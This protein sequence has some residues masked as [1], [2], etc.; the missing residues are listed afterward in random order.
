MSL[1][2]EDLI[3]RSFMFEHEDGLMHRVQPMPAGCPS[4]HWE[5]AHRVTTARLGGRG[6]RQ[7]LTYS[8]AWVRLPDLSREEALKIASSD[9]VPWVTYYP[10]ATTS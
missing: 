3:C 10:Y 7:Q 5:H 9:I 6:E 8:H 2:A 1:H 4:T